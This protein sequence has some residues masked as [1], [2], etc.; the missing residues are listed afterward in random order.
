MGSEK[1]Y[2]PMPLNGWSWCS[3]L[4][5]AIDRTQDL[6]DSLF[7]MLCGGTLREP[8]RRSYP[9]REEALAD[10]AQAQAALKAQEQTVTTTTTQGEP[11]ELEKIKPGDVVR[12][13]RHHGC[14]FVEMW[15]GPVLSVPNGTHVRLAFGDRFV[16]VANVT[17]PCK[18]FLLYRPPRRREISKDDLILKTPIGTKVE[19][20]QNNGGVIHGTFQFVTRSADGV[21]VFLGASPFDTAEVALDNIKAIYTEEVQG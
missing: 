17:N 20:V 14:G 16:D 12:L 11:I 3:D 21:T 1:K 5:T 6:P 13:E 8:N 4:R 9:T 15:Q 19:M 7:A 10:L 2:E 18:I